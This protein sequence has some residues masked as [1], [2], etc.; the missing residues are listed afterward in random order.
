ML[1]GG[2]ISDALGRRVSIIV[3][4][5]IGLAGLIAIHSTSATR[6]PGDYMS[7]GLF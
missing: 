6:F 7:W 4:T 5:L 2:Y 1:G 3:A